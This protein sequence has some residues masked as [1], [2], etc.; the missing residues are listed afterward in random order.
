MS[1]PENYTILQAAREIGVHIPTLCHLHLHDT[2]FVNGS[3]T[4]RVC[5][6]EI[7]GRRNLQPACSTAVAP[8]MSIKTSSRRAISA[9]RAIVG[10]FLS[11]HPKDCLVCE[12]NRD[13]ELQSLAAELGIR[14][15]EYGGHRNLYEKDTTSASIVRNPEKC[16][17]C[18]RCETMCGKIQTVGVYSPV[19]RGF[20]TVMGTE[21]DAKMINT[22]CVF[23]GQCVTVCPTAALTE[24]DN[25][26]EVWKALSDPELFV[27]AQTAP[28]V[29]V[30]L[31]ESFGFEPGTRVTGK[32]TAALRRIGFDMV[33]DTDFGADLTVVEEASELLRRL[34]QGGRLPMLTSCCPAWVKFIESQ[35]P[36]LLDVPSSCK[37]PHEMFGAVAKTYLAGKLGIDPAKMRVISVMPCLAKKFE[38]S[39][40]E[41]AGKEGRRDVDFVL[42]TRELARMIRE[43]GIDFNSLPNENFDTLMG[44]STGAGV[45]FG[46]TG[47]VSE[48][49]LRTVSAWL[50]NAPPKIE[51]ENLRGCDGIK[52]A[53]VELG[54]RTLRVAVS[55]GLGNARRLL[56]EIR[57]GN[58]DFDM[59]EIMACPMGCVG[60]GGQPYH[61]NNTGILKSRAAGLYTEDKE[62]PL[63]LSH[64]NPQVKRLYDE[65]LGERHGELAKK[66]LHTTY[67]AADK[68]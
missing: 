3:G 67:K 34:E 18:R 24:V 28:A 62:K 61:R 15:I 54:G 13:C 11:N 37:S 4:C 43:A 26:A 6:V 55:N 2:E 49:A 53:S 56:E 12:R 57:A 21:F 14:E 60:G 19:H 29:R 63:R 32:M 58:P 45:I 7:E 68:L 35:F 9:R 44:E 36:D 46:T 65:F 50:G 27:V 59:L 66:L 17:L 52:K 41:L 22:P 1:V 38:A 5:M 47:G 31:G 40:E 42:S 39:R 20:D 16:I 23:C 48:A 10:L 51:F 8:G 25:S 64:E 33:L 30:S